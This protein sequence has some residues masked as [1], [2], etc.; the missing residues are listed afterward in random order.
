MNS[1]TPIVVAMALASA[2]SIFWIAEQLDC[3]LEPGTDTCV[4]CVDDC[5]DP[6]DELG[7]PIAE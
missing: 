6:A 3:L 4:G 5:L 1:L 7:E 2:L